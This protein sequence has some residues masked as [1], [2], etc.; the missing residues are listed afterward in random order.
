MSFE[1]E[2]A[3]GLARSLPRCWLSAKG[4]VDAPCNYQSCKQR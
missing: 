4:S 1:R 2:W 3:R